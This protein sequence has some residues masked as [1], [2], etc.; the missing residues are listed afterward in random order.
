M[1]REIL[2][3][4]VNNE[5][6]EIYIKPKTLLVEVL[7]DQLGLT[8]TKRA[9]STSACG[10]CTVILNGMAVKSCSILAVQAEG[11]EILTVEGLADGPNLHALQR[12]FLDHGAYQCGFCTPGMLMSAK[13]LL[14][15]NPR[16]TRE[17]IRQGIHGNLCRCTGYN[18]IVRAVAAV[19]EGRY[20]EEGR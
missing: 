6:H 5:D 16:P 9:C 7:R 20:R 18:S 10:A 12:S 19:A 3:I 11:A 13:A 15:E 14:E 17:E 1:D 8:G 2:R 4:R